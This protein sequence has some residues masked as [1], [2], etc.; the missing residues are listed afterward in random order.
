MRETESVFVGAQNNTISNNSIKVKINIVQ[1]KSKCRLCDDKDKTI[2][3]IERKYSKQAQR[4]YE[5]K[6]EWVGKVI[7]CE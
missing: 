2:H 5:T 3:H 6:H 7:H 4:E 1:Q